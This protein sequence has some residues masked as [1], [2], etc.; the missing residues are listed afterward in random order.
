MDVR[1]TRAMVAIGMIART[2]AGM[3][4][5]LGDSQ[6]GRTFM[7]LSQ[8]ANTM[9]VRSPHTK[10]GMEISAA[11]PTDKLSLIDLGF[12]APAMPIGIPRPA[13]INEPSSTS[14]MEYPNRLSQFVFPSGAEKRI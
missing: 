4:Q 7:I 13:A 11:S 6:L 8:E 1:V 14:L 2:T 12:V 10:F 3:I 5:S 9:I